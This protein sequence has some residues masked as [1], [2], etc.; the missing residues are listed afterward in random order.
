MSLFSKSQTS[1]CHSDKEV[2]SIDRVI[3]D[4][5]AEADAVMDKLSNLRPYHALPSQEGI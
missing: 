1:T 5:M 3:K 2:K 4:L